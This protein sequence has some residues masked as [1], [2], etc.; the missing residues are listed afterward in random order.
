MPHK[1]N[2]SN[3]FLTTFIDIH[4]IPDNTE[5]FQFSRLCV[6]VEDVNVGSII[7]L[8]VCVSFTM[9]APHVSM[10]IYIC[11]GWQFLSSYRPIISFIGKLSAKVCSKTSF[12]Y[13][14]L[15][16][17]KPRGVRSAYFVECILKSKCCIVSPLCH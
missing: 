6:L 2:N 11:L 15:D 10:Y 12:P 4:F 1:Y 17:I 13:L 5:L 9:S 8:I 14:F 16:Y 3:H 7:L